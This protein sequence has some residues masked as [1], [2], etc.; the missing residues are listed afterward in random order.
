VAYN[1]QTPNKKIKLIK[2]E[3]RATQK[4]SLS[5]FCRHQGEGGYE[6]SKEPFLVFLTAKEVV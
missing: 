5:T 2:E 6:L 4:V 1:F 3:G